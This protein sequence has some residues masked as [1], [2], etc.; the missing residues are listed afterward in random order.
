MGATAATCTFTDTFVPQIIVPTSTPTSTVSVVVVNNNAGGGTA[1]P[2]TFTITVS[3]G[4]PTP[5]SFAGSATAVP[6]TVDAKTAYAVS[7][8]SL[9]N[10]TTVKSAACAGTPVAGASALCTITNT[11][12][13]TTPTSTPKA[14]TSTVNVIVINNNTGGGTA[15]P[16]AFTVIVT[17]G[18][19][20]IPGQFAGS[21]TPAPVTL[22]G[23]FP[24]VIIENPV[25]GY[26][27]SK[28]SGCSGV[29]ATGKTATC[30]IT[31]TYHRFWR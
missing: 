21:T 10:Y 30:T 17:G 22:T 26:S 5:A 3:A 29:V 15:Q 27:T 14:T 2:S 31:N 9:A 12:Q 24:Y 23:N 25:A 8:S 16:S 1:Q 11:Y 28:S 19:T 6:V 13:V 7:E 18:G 4:H 20:P